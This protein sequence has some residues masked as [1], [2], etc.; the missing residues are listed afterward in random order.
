MKIRNT[1][2]KSILF[3]SDTTMGLQDCDTDDGLAILLALGS[4]RAHKNVSIEGICTSYGNSTLQ[5]VYNNT[6]SLRNAF[7]LDVPVLK[8]A[9]DK[10]SPESEASH[11]IVEMAHSRPG[12]LSLA[13]TGSTTN[14]KGALQLDPDIL[15][16]YREVVLMGGITQSLLINGKIMNELN[17]ACDAQ[18]T[19]MILESA[20]KG[21]NIIVATA[22]NCLPAYFDQQEFVSRL[23][24]SSGRDK[25]VVYTLCAPWFETMEKWYGLNGF[26]CWDVV[27]SAYILM[28]E[29]FIDIPFSVG[30]NQELLG[31][32]FLEEAFPGLPN[33]CINTPRIIDTQAFCDKIYDLWDLGIKKIGG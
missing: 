11:F 22:N 1:N 21:A 29:L 32:G 19:C 7:G 5:A 9:H 27:V 20:Q 25:G 30:L 31:V 28:P 3:D 13:V 10:D 8:G 14:I 2:K 16:L 4:M 23:W 15:S 6:L 17:F 24:E 33:A 18:A 26:Y 12:E